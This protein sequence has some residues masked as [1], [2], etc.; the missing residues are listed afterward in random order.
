MMQDNRKL[1]IALVVLVALGGVGF[2]I[3]MM[4]SDLNLQVELTAT[5]IHIQHSGAILIPAVNREIAFAEITGYQLFDRLPAIKKVN[6]MDNTKLRIGQF[7]SN[8]L[9][10]VT[11]FVNNL[12]GQAI[13]LQVGSEQIIITPNDYQ[14]F[15]TALQTTR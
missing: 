13:L 9:G 11:A 14:A 12:D 6:G 1:A 8:S 3:Y 4:T 5:G 15:V 10:D 7:T 2:S